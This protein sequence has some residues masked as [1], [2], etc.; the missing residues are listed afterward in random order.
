MVYDC[1]IGM[2]NGTYGFFNLVFVA[3]TFSVIFWGTKYF[4]DSKKTRRGKK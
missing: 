3:I 2:M 1:G 4:F